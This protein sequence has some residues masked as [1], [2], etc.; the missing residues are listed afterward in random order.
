VQ[1]NRLVYRS[2]F[3]ESIRTLCADTQ[4]EVDFGKRADD[5]NGHRAMI[6]R[7]FHDLREPNFRV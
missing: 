6:V 3:V 4:A 7:F 5:D 2:Q 1:S